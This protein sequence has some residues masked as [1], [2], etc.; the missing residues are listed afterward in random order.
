MKIQEIINF[1][2]KD[3][4]WYDHRYSCD[5]ILIGRN[6]LEV[7][8]VYVCWVAT[9]KVIRQAIENDVHFI[10][11][12]EN[13]FYKE[14]TTLPYNIRKFKQI[15]K[16]LCEKNNI[17]I[18]RCHD[19]WDRFP[20]YGVCDTLNAKCGFNFVREKTTDFHSYADVDEKYS[21]K[22][23]A[24]KIA[25]ALRN[26]GS[27]HVEVFGNEEKKVK[28]LGIGVGAI[29]DTSWMY[30]KECDCMVLADDGYTNWID[31]QWAIDAEIPCIIYHHSIN[32]KPGIEHMAEYLK[33]NIAGCKFTYIDEGYDFKIIDSTVNK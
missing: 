9:L 4:Y 25:D 6:D 32:E 26:Y 28:R 5:H 21:A 7:D 30:N 2:R 12:H 20:K 10:I 22:E 19:G 16:E 15:K 23:I 33:E 24:Q 14:G 11:S 13:C 17:T 29:S 31:L 1:L 3:S 27:D 18:Y 8:K